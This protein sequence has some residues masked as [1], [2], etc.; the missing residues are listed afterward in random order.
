MLF[1]GGWNVVIWLKVIETCDKL[2]LF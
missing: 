1:W 2:R